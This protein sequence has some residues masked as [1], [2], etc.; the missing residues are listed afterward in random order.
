MDESIQKLNDWVA[1]V[2]DF[3]PTPW[4]RLPELDLY[5]DQ[6]IT[7]KVKCGSHGRLYGSITSQEIAAALKEQHGVDVD[8][9]KIECEPIRQVGDVDIT[10]WLYSG[11][12]T[13]MKVS[14]IAA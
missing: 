14:V 9:R 13:P 12:T 5:M 7:L 11:V 1:A 3:E 10:V 8:K 6:V 2:H 4:E